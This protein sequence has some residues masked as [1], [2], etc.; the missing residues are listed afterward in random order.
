MTL[1]ETKPFKLPVISFDIKTGP[2]ECIIDKKIKVDK[3]K[4]VILYI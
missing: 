1:L 4:Y 2:K 3:Y